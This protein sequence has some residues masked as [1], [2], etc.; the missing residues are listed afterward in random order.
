MK[1]YKVKFISKDDNQFIF[2]TEAE[3]EMSA[4]A[5]GE[6]RIKTNCWINYSYVFDSIVEYK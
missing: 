1:K 4:I 5:K 3:T 6:D 2:S